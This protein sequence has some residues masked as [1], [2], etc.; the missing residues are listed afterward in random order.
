MG[1]I[2]SCVIFCVA[3]ATALMS[4]CASDFVK[5]AP[6][7]PEKYERLGPA[8]ASGCG[9]MLILSTAYNFIPVMLNSRVERAYQNEIGRASCRERV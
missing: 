4:G 9:T 6:Q 5:V 1:R 2:Q 7:P 8:T 3:G